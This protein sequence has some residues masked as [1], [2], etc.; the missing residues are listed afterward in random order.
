MQINEADQ[1]Q[2]GKDFLLKLITSVYLDSPALVTQRA[3]GVGSLD[4]SLSQRL[5]DG[6]AFPTLANIRGKIDSPALEALLT[7]ERAFPVRVPHRGEVMVDPSHVCLSMT[8]NSSSMTKDLSNRSYVVRLRKQS[9][10]YQFQKYAEGDLLDHIRANQP[11]YLGA[12]FA[13]VRHWMQSGQPTTTETRHDFRQWARIMDWITQNVFNAGPLLEGHEEAKGRL[14]DPAVQFVREIAVVVVNTGTPG[15]GYA[16]REIAELAFANSIE[17]PGCKTFDD[18]NAARWIGIQF[19]KVLGEE[20]VRRVDG[21]EVSV[22]TENV[23]STQRQ[24][25]AD[26]KI[27]RF[28]T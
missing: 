23:Y 22:Q 18:A 3:G 6:A 20:Q 28:S 10:G 8:S 7:E 21:Y 5:S 14:S 16:A 25:Y 24:Q 1:S 2:T 9:P 4:E 27:Y 15:R 26:M 12:V 11:F 19:K 17:I 13:V